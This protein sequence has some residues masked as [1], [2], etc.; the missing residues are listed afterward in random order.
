M[1]VAVA[2]TPT[3]D[4]SSEVA[5]RIGQ[6]LV[7]SRSEGVESARP[8]SVNISGLPSRPANAGSKPADGR[9]TKPET[10]EPGGPISSK[11]APPERERAEFDQMVRSIRLQ[12]GGRRSTARLRLEPPELGRVRIDVRVD[13]DAVRVDVQAETEAARHRLVDRAEMLK[14]GLAEHG[15]RVER[16]E[17]AVDAPS[18]GGERG[19]ASFWSSSPEGQHRGSHEAQSDDGAQGGNRDVAEGTRAAKRWRTDVI[20]DQRLDIRV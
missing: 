17:V 15:I 7:A 9:A 12:M 1:A 19:S 14:A 2:A 20:V 5:R 16:F 18:D 3:S 11:T 6:V 8:V 4:A 10:E 13:G